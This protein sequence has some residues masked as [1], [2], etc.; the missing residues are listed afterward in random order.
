MPFQIDR[1]R[2]CGLALCAAA[3]PAAAPALSES[4]ARSLVQNLVAEINAVIDSGRSEAAMLKAFEGIF[5]KYAD[6]AAVAAYA[7]GV[8]GRRASPAQRQAFSDAFITY[9]ARKYG[10]RFRE[11]EG[12][13][14]E[15]QGVRAVKSYFEVPTV[16]YLRG[17]APFEVTFQVSDRTGR[18]LFFNMF[19]EGVNMLLSERTEIGAMLDRRGGD[20]DAMIADLRRAA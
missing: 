7:M 2:F 17:E 18:P 11:F 10:R 5:A 3:W 6:T 19:V 13:R 8:D 4:A 12:G 16:V 15:V 14:F 9:V 20:I 1:R